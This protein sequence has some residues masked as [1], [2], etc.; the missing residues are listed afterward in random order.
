MHNYCFFQN[1]KTIACVFV[2]FF[3]LL[4]L[5]S[6]RVISL[7]FYFLALSCCCL[8]FFFIRIF[9]SHITFTLSTRKQKKNDANCLLFVVMRDFVFSL[10]FWMHLNKYHQNDNADWLK[11]HNKSLKILN[12][13]IIVISDHCDHWTYE[14]ANTIRKT[15]IVYIHM[16][17]YIGIYTHI[18]FIYVSH[19]FGC[20]LRHVTDWFCA[21]HCSP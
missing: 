8:V 10:L 15:V 12:T 5:F 3:F 19:A 20:T 9:I 17:I 16:Y 18:T 2:M 11:K 14:A 1:A 7:Q 21:H 13:R 4:F 6:F